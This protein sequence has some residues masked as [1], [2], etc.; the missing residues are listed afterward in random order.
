MYTVTILYP[1]E[2]GITFDEDY[3]LR[4]HMPLVD[5]VWKSQGL[6]NARVARFSADLAGQR[7][8]YLI[9]AILDWE[10]EDAMK[11]ATQGPSASEVFAD[12]PKFTNVKPITLAGSPRPW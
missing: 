2:D 4:T 10:S 12:I 5:R 9:M 11:A 3:Y 8:Q 7:P 6:T 1:N